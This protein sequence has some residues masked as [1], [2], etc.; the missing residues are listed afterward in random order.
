MIESIPTNSH[1]S[2]THF[3]QCINCSFCKE[4]HQWFLPARDLVQGKGSFDGPLMKHCF[5][6]D[7]N[8]GYNKN[9][10][11]IATMQQEDL[12]AVAHGENYHSLL[13]P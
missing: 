13:G 9:T 6:C 4:F 2:T 5:T 8:T 3:P 1:E 11:K 12:I 7:H 10:E